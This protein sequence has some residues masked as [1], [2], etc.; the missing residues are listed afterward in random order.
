M[1]KPHDVVVK[2]LVEG[3]PEG[4]PP[5]LDLPR[6]PVVAIDA[7]IATVSGA[8]DKVLRVET[9]PPYLLHLDFYSGHDTAHVLGKLR[10]Y[11][12]ILDER[13]RLPVYS[14]AVLLR[15]EADSPNLTGEYSRAV[16][17]RAP[18]AV[19]RYEALRVWRQSPEVFLSGS[20]GLLPLAPIGDARADELP[21]IIERMKQLLRRRPRRMDEGDFWT[22]TYILLGM[23]Y[24]RETAGVLLRGITAMEESVTYQAIIEQGEA[25]GE[26]RGVEKGRLTE[27]R[28]ILLRV[29]RKR[30]GDPDRRVEAAIEAIGDHERLAD[31]VVRV[32]DVTDW[33]DLLPPP[34]P[35]GRTRRKPPSDR[36]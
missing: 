27:A 22:A 11:N 7:D 16:P 18:H 13:H 14:V 10:R 28:E 35:R 24:S 31:L 5:A 21:A 26:A 9:D 19:F 12:A 30:L 34:R 33:N 20:P 15:P 32:A 3:D 1:S 8:V 29:G 36:G 25:R 23:R 2:T 6:G 4:W 17:G